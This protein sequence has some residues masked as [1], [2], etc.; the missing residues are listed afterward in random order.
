MGLGG[1]DHSC[2]STVSHAGVLVLPHGKAHSTAFLLLR[3]KGSHTGMRTLS[4]LSFGVGVVAN[5]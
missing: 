1:L 3:G 5:V 4:L 2:E